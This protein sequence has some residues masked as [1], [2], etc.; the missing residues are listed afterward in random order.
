MN[1]RVRRLDSFQEAI[2]NEGDAMLAE[3]F[4]LVLES[5]I[6]GGRTYPDGSPRVI[7]TSPHIP[8][9]LPDRK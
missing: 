9:K 7:S 2:T 8:V 3:K 5:L 6:R 1:F 4:F